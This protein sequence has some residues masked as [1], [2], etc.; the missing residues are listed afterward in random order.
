MVRTRPGVRFP[1]EACSSHTAVAQ[2]VE[3]WSPKPEVGG[4]IPSRRAENKCES[5]RVRECE[6][7][8]PDHAWVTVPSFN[9]QD[10]GL[11][12]RRSGFDSPWH[13]SEVPSARCPVPRN[14]TGRSILDTAVR[15]HSS[16]G[17]ARL[18]HGRGRGFESRCPLLHL[19]VRLAARHPVLSRES[20]G[21]NPARGAHRHVAQWLEHSAD[22]RGV[23]GSNP[24]VSTSK[25]PVP[26]AQC[27][28]TRDGALE[29]GHFSRSGSPAAEGACFTCRRSEVPPPRTTPRPA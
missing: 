14:G 1:A 27:P 23:G 24:P 17:R 12:L 11:S 3:R 28:G 20:A 9:G 26:G 5:A 21:S 4:S 2:Q 10:T 13:R 16:A 7:A 29:P 18:R 22:T 25:C 6:S 15:G 19:P 8:S